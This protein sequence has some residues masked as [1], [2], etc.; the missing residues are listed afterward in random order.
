MIARSA[1]AENPE[2]TKNRAS[3]EST[4]GSAG[5]QAGRRLVLAALRPGGTGRPVPIR[6][7]GLGACLH[8]PPPMG[9]R[10]PLDAA[11]PP[12][13][14]AEGPPCPPPLAGSRRTLQGGR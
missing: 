13:R 5:Q 14:V 11:L 9:A 1:R 2:R 3:R 4:R 12:V 8:G 10:R 7:R 6:P